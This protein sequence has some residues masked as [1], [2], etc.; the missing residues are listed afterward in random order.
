MTGDTRRLALRAGGGGGGS[1]RRFA[2]RGE[3]GGG[4]RGGLVGDVR[5]DV[6]IASVVVD[7]ACAGLNS[8]VVARLAKKK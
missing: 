4:M 1:D 2:P 3:T 8:I 6:N 7:V 5:V